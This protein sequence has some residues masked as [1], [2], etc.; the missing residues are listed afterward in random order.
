MR[1]PL[2]DWQL[3]L[4]QAARLNHPNLAP[5]VE[6]GVQD[7]WPWVAYEIAACQTLAERTPTT[8][9]PGS[10]VATLGVHLLQGLAF[11]HEAG[12]VHHDLQP[13]LVWMEDGGTPR[14][15]G[16]AVASAMARRHCCIVH[17]RSRR[18]LRAQRAAAE[19]D[20]LA[21]GVLMHGLLV[22]QPA[23]DDADVGRVVRRVPPMGREFV[24]LPWTR[25]N[26]WPSRCGPSSTA[27]PTARN[28]SATAMH[29]PCCARWK[30]G[31][32]SM[33]MPGRPAGPAHGPPAQ[34]R[35]AAGV[36][37]GASAPRAWP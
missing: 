15:A 20:V 25:R 6:S 13:Y 35:R 8:G 23:L 16:L 29:A 37:G 1:K 26:R 2:D 27:P 4:R 32:R 30:A 24:R 11:A 19:L 7:G 14:L 5:A 17:G 36:P 31:C 9:M 22:G 18:T 33:P 3:A 21:V 34:R 12:L 28:A 10:E